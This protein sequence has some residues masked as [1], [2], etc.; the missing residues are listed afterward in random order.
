M[1]QTLD[2]HA[3]WVAPGSVLVM[4]SVNLRGLIVAMEGGQKVV[5]T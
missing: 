1:C 5:C 2:R 3:C 4:I